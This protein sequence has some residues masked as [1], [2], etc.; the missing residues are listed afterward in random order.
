MPSSIAGRGASSWGT[1]TLTGSSSTM[2]DSITWQN[3]SSLL[4]K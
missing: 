1:T 3:A 2:T 4:R